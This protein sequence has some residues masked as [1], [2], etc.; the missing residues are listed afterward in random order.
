MRESCR[1]ERYKHLYQLT[2]GLIFFGIPFG[3]LRTKELERS[4]KN[5]DAQQQNP[6]EARWRRD[7]LDL[8]QQLE[9]DSDYLEELRVNVPEI[10]NGLAQRNG[11]ISFYETMRTHAVHLVSFSR[12]LSLPHH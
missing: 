9:I 3:G 10:L 12:S 7:M 8:I 6:E 11:I 5:I 2:K 1:N 4:H